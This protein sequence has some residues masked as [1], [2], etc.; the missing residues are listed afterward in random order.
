MNVLLCGKRDGK[1]V[2]ENE[3]PVVTRGARKVIDDTYRGKATIKET[4]EAEIK[5]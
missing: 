5:E 2:V 1:I 3:T 4:A